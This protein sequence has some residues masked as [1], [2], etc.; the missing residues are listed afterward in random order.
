MITYRI[1]VKLN[2]ITYLWGGKEVK[3]PSTTKFHLFFHVDDNGE[4]IKFGTAKVKDKDPDLH[5][6]GILNPGECFSIPLNNLIG[7]YASCTEQEHT[8]VDCTV[9]NALE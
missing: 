6:M 8:V 2:E 4:R 9:L 5:E 7:V 1:K 3:E